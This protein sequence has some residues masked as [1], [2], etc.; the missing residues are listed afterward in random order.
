MTHAKE[1]LDLL[2]QGRRL[3]LLAAVKVSD[4]NEA[5]LIVHGVLARAMNGVVANT[6]LAELDADLAYALRLHAG[7]GTLVLA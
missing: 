1:S 3:N 6:T 5:H 4:V 7:R 2:A